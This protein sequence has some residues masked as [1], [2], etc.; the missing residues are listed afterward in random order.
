[1]W[2][3]ICD[4]RLKDLCLL[5]S[6]ELWDE[7]VE[8]N[9]RGQ[10][11]SARIKRREDFLLRILISSSAGCKANGECRAASFSPFC[12]V[13]CHIRGGDKPSCPPTNFRFCH[14]LQVPLGLNDQS[15]QQ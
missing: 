4:A 11:L 2:L 6:V 1:M 13:P 5:G 8:A 10:T 15:G 9:I 7:D 12:R 14:V 3:N